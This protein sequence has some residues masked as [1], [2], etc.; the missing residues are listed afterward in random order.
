[1]ATVFVL[2]KIQMVPSRGTKMSLFFG[3]TDSSPQSLNCSGNVSKKCLTFIL[4][5]GPKDNCL[6]LVQGNFITDQFK[7]TTKPQ[8]EFA[9][10]G[11]PVSTPK[12]ILNPI[13][14]KITTSNR[15][16]KCAKANIHNGN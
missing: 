8:A 7:V 15:V 4:F 11:L 12:E 5:S 13:T 9:A 6:P 2:P 3:L 1:M 14:M 16:S 10:A